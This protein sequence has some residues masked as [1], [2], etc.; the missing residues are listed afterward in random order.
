MPLIHWLEEKFN[1][2]FLYL[3]LRVRDRG[4]SAQNFVKLLIELFQT[5]KNTPIYF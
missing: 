2:R 1:F 4:I 5:K 3:A